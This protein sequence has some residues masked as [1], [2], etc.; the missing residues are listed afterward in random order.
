MADNSAASAFWRNRTERG[1]CAIA[2]ARP[3]PAELGHLYGPTRAGSNDVILAHKD[4]AFTNHSAIGST[5]LLVRESL[6][7]FLRSIA[8]ISGYL[9][10]R[11]DA[12]EDPSSRSSAAFFAL[13]RMCE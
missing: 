10:T 12:L 11:D 9:P 5:E 4:R 2:D 8:Q 6:V 3:P 13:R 1:T 7:G